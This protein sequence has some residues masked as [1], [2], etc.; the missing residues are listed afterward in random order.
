MPYILI[1]G[2]LCR[3]EEVNVLYSFAP[4]A[5]YLNLNLEFLDFLITK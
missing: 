5:N 4:T 1:D 2:T 3:E